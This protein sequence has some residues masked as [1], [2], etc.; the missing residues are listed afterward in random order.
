VCELIPYEQCVTMSTPP[1]SVYESTDFVP[2]ATAPNGYT[3]EMHGCAVDEGDA[4][5]VN[6]VTAPGVLNV[7]SPPVSIQGLTFNAQF[8][9]VDGGLEQASG[10]LTASKTYLGTISAGPGSGTLSALSIP[11][12]DVPD[13]L[14]QPSALVDAGAGSDAD[15]GVPDADG[16]VA[17]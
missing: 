8:V 1:V 4:G 7:A 6:I 5:V 11:D 2:K 10:T 14:P 9:P 16:A 13:G 12:A 3:F 15:S 17:D